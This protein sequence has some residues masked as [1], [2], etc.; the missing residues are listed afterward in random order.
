VIPAQVEAA[1]AAAPVFGERERKGGASEAAQGVGRAQRGGDL[2]A[3][4]GR[5]RHGARPVTQQQAKPAAFARRQRQ[6]PRRGEVGAGLR[7]LGERHRDG[8]AAQRLLEG[9]QEI[10]RTRQA[11][12]HQPPHRQSEEFEAGAIGR[13]GFARAEIGLDE[14]C[15]AGVVP[16][17]RRQRQRKAKRR[18]KLR[19]S[20]RHHLVQGAIGEATL[21]GR[22]EGTHAKPQRACIEKGAARIDLRK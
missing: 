14:E 2:E 17:Q 16:C 1:A 5:G 19:R 21:Q 10:E 6:P 9:A 18:A 11:Q 12:Q 4:Q 13:A 8:G 20:R 7:Q 22:I 3:G 15:R